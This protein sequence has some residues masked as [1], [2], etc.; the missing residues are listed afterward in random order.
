MSEPGGSTKGKP[1]HIAACVDSLSS[2]AAEL[3]VSTAVQVHSC[4]RYPFS[5]LDANAVFRLGPPV[6]AGAQ[7]QPLHHSETRRGSVV[8]C[9]QGPGE[10]ALLYPSTL[11]RSRCFTMQNRRGLVVM[12]L[13][14]RQG[15]GSAAAAGA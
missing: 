1:C 9:R 3:L 4:R 6:Q 5:S 11:Y 7:Q 14:Y 2:A 12:T 8:T 15:P 13:M 10:G